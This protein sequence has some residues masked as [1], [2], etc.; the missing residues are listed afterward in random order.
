MIEYILVGFSTFFASFV[1]FYSGFGL[2][3]ILMPVMAIFLP[4]PLA[5]TLTAI[6]H[7]I[8]NSLTTSF[9][10]KTIDW[11]NA[12]RFGITALIASVPGAILLKKL[13]L[14]PSIKEFFILGIKSEIS[15]LHIII[16]FL[17]ILFASLEIYNN[18]IYKFNNLYVGGAISGFFGGF[19][20]HQGAFRSLF[21]VTF[22]KDKKTFIGT[23]AIISCGV[24]VVRII[25][26]GLSFWNLAINIDLS[27]LLFAIFGALVGNIF[28]MIFV[29]KI[30]IS[31][32]KKNIILLLYIFGSLLILGI[33]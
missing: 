24:D 9:F 7:L 17:L 29:D 27:L 33:L 3:T 14:Y 2:G 12:S 10:W 18:K 8:H 26:Y 15:L 25:I 13:S 32:I 21:L 16:G 6:I 1:T 23:N 19:S 20:G 4:L 31:F 30:T 11:V 22:I 28:G 5:I